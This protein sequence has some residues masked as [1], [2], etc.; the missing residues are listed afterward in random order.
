[1]ASGVSLVAIGGVDVG[2]GA[3]QQV[4]RLDVI[5]IDRPVQRRGAVHLGRVD[6]GVLLEQRPK[7]RLVAFHHR[8]RDIAAAGGAGQLPRAARA[9]TMHASRV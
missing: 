6:V 8:V 1:M 2:A 7:R 4:G 3:N 9:A 5:A